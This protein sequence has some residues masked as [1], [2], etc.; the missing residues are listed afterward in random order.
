MVAELRIVLLEEGAGKKGRIQRTQVEM[1][2]VRR[3]TG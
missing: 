1:P 3:K 2:G